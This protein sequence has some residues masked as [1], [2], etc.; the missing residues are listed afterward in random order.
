MERLKQLV[1]AGGN[2][3]GLFSRLPR[4]IDLPLIG[5]AWASV[6]E[7]SPEGAALEVTHALG[8]LI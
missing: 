5:L 8:Q 1:A 7:M 3:F 6:P 4:L 2:S